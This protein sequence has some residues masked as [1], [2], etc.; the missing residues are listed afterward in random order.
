MKIKLRYFYFLLLT[1]IVAC[2]SDDVGIDEEKPTISIDYADGFPQGCSEL[3]R[4][5]T[6]SFRAQTTDNLSLASY[7]ID[8]HHNF[9]HHTHDDQVGDCSLEDI[10]TAVNPLIFIENYTIDEGGTTYEINV[11]ITIPDDV[12]TGDYHCAYSV[13]DATGWQSRTSIDIK[14]IE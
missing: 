6:Y 8:I 11:S 4:G 13:T 9:D 3:T 14:I 7:S 2:S 1:L 5:E 10:K 12:D